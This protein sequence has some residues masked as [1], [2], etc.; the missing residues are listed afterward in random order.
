MRTR[1]RLM[2]FF[3]AALLVSAFDVYSAV[4]GSGGQ[5]AV[6][7]VFAAIFAGIALYALLA[8]LR[9]ER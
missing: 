7:W 4:R 9:G 2:L 5:P 6:S 1:N 8:L 3:F